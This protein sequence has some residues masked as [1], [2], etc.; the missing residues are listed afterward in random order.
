MEDLKDL[1]L[2]VTKIEQ[3]MEALIQAGEAD[4]REVKLFQKIGKHFI[5]HFQEYRSALTAIGLGFMGL[6]VVRMAVRYKFLQHNGGAPED[7]HMF[8]VE[9]GFMVGAGV[10]GGIAAYCL[11]GEVTVG[12]IAAGAGAGMF[13]GLVLYKL[14]D[15]LRRRNIRKF[16]QVIGFSII[17][18]PDA[19]ADIV[20][21]HVDDLLFE[22][23]EPDSLRL[24]NAVHN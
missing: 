6:Q 16:F 10:A 11:L 7:W 21:D 20:M 5:S 13:A 24:V 4:P 9:G 1:E 17:H 15:K 22:A 23:R 8:W 19:V 2:L 12:E 14:C 3:E 18:L